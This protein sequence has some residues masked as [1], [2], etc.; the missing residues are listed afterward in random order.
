MQG[1][2]LV[3]LQGLP[4]AGRSWDTDVSQKLLQDSGEGVVDTLQGLTSDMH[5]QLTLEHA[6]EVFRLQGRW[7]GSMTRR[8]CRCNVP[9]DWQMQGKTERDYQLRQAP[10]DDE[11]GSE[12]EFIAPPGNI[13]LL[14]IL[15]EDVWLA[16]QADVVCSESCKGLCSYCGCNRNTRACQCE[17]KNS[18]HPFAALA[19]LKLDA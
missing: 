3:T 18:G 7:Q 6:D 13:Y 8:C 19:A 1:K 11:S 4:S 15:R 14:D 17:Q 16:W 2:W 9:F 5:W 10:Y 12:C